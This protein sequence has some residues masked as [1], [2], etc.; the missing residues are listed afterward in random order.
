[1]IGLTVR[2][3][4]CRYTF[5][6][7]EITVA[8][9]LSFEDDDVDEMLDMFSFQAPDND[10][11]DNDNPTT[12]MPPQGVLLND[13]H[14]ARRKSTTTTGDSTNNEIND[15]DDKSTDSFLEFL[16][17]TAAAVT[18]TTTTTAATELSILDKQIAAITIVG[19]ESIDIG[20]GIGDGNYT[21]NNNDRE[22]KNTSNDNDGFLS[23]PSIDDSILDWLDDDD[24]KEIELLQKQKQ[25]E[26]LIPAI[27]PPK[28]RI[29]NRLEEKES[30]S[31][32]SSTDCA[33]QQHQSTENFLA[34]SSLQ[35]QEQPIVIK[36]AS[37][38]DAVRSTKST[39]DDIR[40]LFE[41]EGCVVSTETRPYLW[42]KLLCD[43]TIEE[44]LQSSLVDSFQQW[45]QK[46]WLITNKNKNKNNNHHV[47]EKEQEINT[48]NNNNQPSPEERLDEWLI[49]NESTTM[50]SSTNANN[51]GD[52]QSYQQALQALLVNYYDTG[53]TSN[54]NDLDADF[55]KDPL[56]PPLICS[57]LTARIPTPIIPLLL[58]QIIPSFMPVLTL[59]IEDRE[60]VA[61]CLHHELYLL[62]SYHLPYLVN[63]LDK[64]LTGWY[65]YKVYNNDDNYDGWLPQ[66]WLIS[67]LAGE[68]NNTYMNRRWHVRLWD[69]IF[70]SNNSSLRFFLVLT[71]LDLHAEELL[72]LTGNDLK[73]EF[74]RAVSFSS[75]LIS[76]EAAPKNEYVD[77]VAQLPMTKEDMYDS[78]ANRWVEKWCDRAVVLWQETPI[79]V[80]RTLKVLEDEAVNRALISRQEAKEKQIQIQHE[81]EVKAAQDAKAAEKERQADAA[82][83]RLTRARLV[84]YYRQYN[85]GKES[86]IDKIMK[87]YHGRFDV[88]DAKLKIKYGVSFNPALKP[89]TMRKRNSSKIM[90]SMN[91]S[92]GTSRLSSSGINLEQDTRFQLQ[93]RKIPVVQVAPRE[94]LPVICWRKKS[95]QGQLSKLKKTSKIDNDDNE[96]TP[97]KFYLVDSRPQS[98]VREQGKLPTSLH[99][100][101]DKFST[102][103]EAMIESLRGSVHICV[104]LCWHIIRVAHMPKLSK[105][106][107]NC[108][109]MLTIFH[110]PLLFQF[111]YLSNRT[112]VV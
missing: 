33:K 66:S 21:D 103:E 41:K 50:L 65:K 48:T 109:P 9:S 58:S 63:H 20:N 4:F 101:P 56:L 110:L 36:C 102:E 57:L 90:N 61:T 7:Q 89:K 43:K 96:R 98:A 108:I 76:N 64:H 99:F 1:M 34:S 104:S 30:P 71:I 22:R 55:W 2:P 47:E 40:N 39:K 28:E 80:T 83:L 112:I 29:R 100:N 24:A 6:N 75:N 15:D 74:Q 54:Q 62:S 38:W 59:C 97:L 27:Q 67:H 111:Q 44:I 12:R 92:L 5:E 25:E 91:T 52:V 18:T 78:H 79:S 95:D 70:S 19:D 82:R 86:N 73:E 81:A 68:T 84:A 23:I 85:P 94:V 42:C 17:D 46:Y 87:A 51:N 8:M 106:P 77:D 60:I 93:D 53:N 10:N 35:Q 107:F 49:E 11:A 14:D 3:D 105:F 72:L 26:S 45:E 88:L 69:I 37:L 16:L 32:S 31:S 13:D